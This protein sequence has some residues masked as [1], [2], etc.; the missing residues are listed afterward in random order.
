MLIQDI[1]NLS[2]SSVNCYY[3]LKK[4]NGAQAFCFFYRFELCLLDV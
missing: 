1:G 4:D 2:V 3:F